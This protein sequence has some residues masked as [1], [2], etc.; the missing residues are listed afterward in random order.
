MRGVPS[1]VSR[2]GKQF[3]V[4]GRAGALSG[5][6]LDILGLSIRVALTRMFLPNATFLILDEPA[7]AMDDQRTA[8][9]M[10]FL[11]AAG[12]P[13]TLLVTHEEMSES[14]ADNLIRI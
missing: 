11:V 13:Q 10:G 5:S 6:T 9:T 7:A 4:D 3:K 12:F 14:V 1:V 2:E 8:A